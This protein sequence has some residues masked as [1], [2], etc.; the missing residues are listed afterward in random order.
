MMGWWK[1]VMNFLEGRGSD[2]LFGL[3]GAEDEFSGGRR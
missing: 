1:V 3:L 2:F